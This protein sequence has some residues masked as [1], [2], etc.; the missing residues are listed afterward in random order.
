[1]QKW[2]SGQMH[3]ISQNC[4]RTKMSLY[5]HGDLYWYPFSGISVDLVV[6]SSELASCSPVFLTNADDKFTLSFL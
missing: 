2:L 6:H 3:L 1:M 5:K 4:I